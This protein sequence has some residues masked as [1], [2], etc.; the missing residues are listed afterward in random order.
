M[1]TALL[2]AITREREINAFLD[3]HGQTGISFVESVLD[4]LDV[5]WSINRK[6]LENI[7][8]IGKVIVVANHP[9]GAVDAFA[10]MQLLSQVRQNGKVRVLA[11]SILMQVPQ[12][13]ERLI[14]V[15]NISGTIS[16]ESVQLIEQALAAEEA[17]LIFP[18]GEVSRFRPWGI[19]D[20]KWKRGFLKLARR[21]GAPVLPVHIDARNS[22]M[23]YAVSAINKAFSMVLLPREVMAARGARLHM[24][25]GELVS[26]RS[27]A[28]ANMSV[29]QHAKTFRK[30]LYQIGASQPGIYATEKCIAHPEHRQQLRYELKHAEKIG[31]TSDGKVIYLVDSRQ[32]PKL[33]REIGRLREYTFRKVE[34]GT[35]GKRDN[36]RFDFHYRHIV[37]WDDADLEV[38]GAYRIGEC[39]AIL[40]KS[41]EDNLY[42]HQLCHFSP[43]FSGEVLPHAIEL[44]RSFVQPR[45]WG[46]RALDYL[47]HGIG[48]YLRHHPEV[49]YMYGPVSLSHA[50]PR[51]ARDAIVWFYLHYFGVAEP[52]LTAR[53]PYR[54]SELTK[55]EMCDM[56]YGESY[57]QNFRILRG[58]LKSLDVSVPTLF[59][60][61]SELCEPGGVRFFDFG[62][63]QNFGDCID[64]YLLVDVK[65]IKPSRRQRYIDICDEM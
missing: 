44:G 26:E 32:A 64:G 43:E 53:N 10:L 12:L 42:M 30:H 45:Y 59:K 16:R 28:N 63:D 7:P 24:T 58:Y 54:L 52:L 5:S 50:F 34:E 31:A 6:E 38:A 17:V 14:P 39:A 15:D 23:F 49:R 21:S 29:K 40:G 36:D 41:G 61:Y 4:H 19:R 33:L 55:K 35:G 51:T 48:A 22:V 46:S 1:A 27:L 3:N 18:A 13:A 2:R 20:G 8:A 11:N 60:Q 9:L 62:L 47:W 25:I 37:L 65:K 57:E 56:F